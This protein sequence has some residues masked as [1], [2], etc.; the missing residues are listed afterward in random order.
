MI[1]DTDDP[2]L[3]AYALGELDPASHREIEDLLASSDEARRHVEEI[4]QTARWLAEELQKERESMPPFT[5]ANHELIEQTLQAQPILIT[6]RSWWRKNLRLLSVAATLLAGATVGLVSWTTYQNHDVREELITR[7]PAPSAPPAALKPGWVAPALKTT[8]T[9]ARKPAGE[10]VLEE[11]QIMLRSVMDDKSQNARFG[12]LDRTEPLKAMA[13]TPPMHATES[14]QLLAAASQPAPP[15]GT[16]SMM[17][18]AKTKQRQALNPMAGGTSGMPANQGQGRSPTGSGMGGMGG[19]MSTNRLAGRQPARGYFGRGASSGVTYGK[20]VDQVPA[21]DHR[22]SGKDVLTLAENS[23]ATAKKRPAPLAQRALDAKGQGGGPSSY[24]A[25]PSGPFA[26]Q[27]QRQGQP[28]QQDQAA[29]QSQSAGAMYQ[30]AQNGAA[31]EQGLPA[32]H[33]NL[34]QAPVVA[35]SEDQ[36][37]QRSVQ[38]ASSGKPVSQT[39]EQQ[40]PVQEAVVQNGPQQAP[41][42][43]VTAPQQ[44]ETP[45]GQVAAAV[46]AEGIVLDQEAFAP[47]ADNPFVPTLPDTFSTFSVDVDTASYSNV[48]RYLLQ[49]GQLP[50]P[51]AVRIEELLNYFSYEDAPPPPGSADPFAIHVEVARCPWNGDHRLARIGIMGTPVPNNERPSANLVFLIDVSGSMADANKLP[52]VKWGLQ[53][54]VEQLDG[55]DHLAIVVY[56]ATSN[57]LMPSTPC[58]P[59][60]RPEILSKIDQLQAAGGTNASDGLQIAYR[61]AAEHLKKD[62]INRIILAT[63]GDFNI[64][65]T[66]RSELIKLI[67]EKA[68]SKVFLTVLGFGAG[69][70]K[71][72]N[73]EALAD[74]GNGHYAYIDSTDEA[75]RVL[76]R[77]LGATLVTIAK[78]VKIQVDFNPAK[79]SAYRL[80]GYENRAMADEDFKNDAR[81]AGDIGAGHHVTALYELVPAG[82]E[83]QLVTTE[84]SKFV[85]QAE[86]KGNLPESFTIKLRYKQPETNMPRQMEQNVVDRGLDYSQASGDFKFASAVAGFGMLLRNSVYK[87]NLSY[88][89]VLELASPGLSHDPSGYRKEFVELARRAQQLT[90]G[91]APIPGR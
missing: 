16:S 72:T 52:L 42:L 80:I 78:D 56:A 73:L 29:N 27:N 5:P 39:G 91:A 9:L 1:F 81:D 53:R 65:I 64:G 74:K 11:R 33:Q 87:G 59:G 47:I 31:P 7:A 10:R 21:G 66:Q 17:G 4:R 19:M 34:A 45:Q 36:K 58:D 90:P 15:Q 86:V 69:N 70:L 8:E 25:S 46:Q 40:P 32:L 24:S 67:E 18:R 44:P 62:G 76:V 14:Q 28:M 30:V 48:R 57:V 41:A 85:K 55:R 79:V 60:H 54:L 13:G 37:G 35:L 61:V 71:D 82:K 49:S 43:A 68:R 3:T 51:D 20:K 88:P 2:R 23:G 89:I 12:D 77:Q 22:Q 75:Q 84:V 83:P 50:P 6:S 38:Q 63:D 26:Y